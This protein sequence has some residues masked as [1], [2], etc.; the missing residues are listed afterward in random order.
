M[1]QT[2]FSLYFVLCLML[3]A[4][5]PLQAHATH[6]WGNY[7]WARN[8]NPLA[9]DLGDNVS[10]VW[11]SD[12]HLTTASSDWS[13]SSVLDTTIVTGGTTSRKCRPTSGRIEVC[14]DSYG[15]NGWLG[16]AQIWASGDH[17]TQGVTKLNDF[18]FSRAPYNTS[19]WRQMV[20]CQEVGHTFGLDHQDETFDNP[21]LGT[22][23][24]YT[25]DPDGTINNQKS[26]VH[27]DQHDYDEL[28]II[29]QHLD[30][31]SS[32]GGGNSGNCPGR[33]KNCN[34][35]NMPPAMADIDF[36]TPAQW[37]RLVASSNNGRTE[38]YELD[39]GHGYKVIT[40]VIWAMDEDR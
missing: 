39:F 20:I 37:G 2:R 7:H 16:I 23:M 18:Y 30:G 15:N 34:N 26:N 29:Y 6:A 35:G 25:S 40:H 4:I 27:P 21:N 36:D 22:C 38:V 9:L 33:K 32:G 10:G 1:H 28:G 11:D 14:N 5:L 3:V 24:D 19:A 13:A 8:A 17:I 31:S 12:G